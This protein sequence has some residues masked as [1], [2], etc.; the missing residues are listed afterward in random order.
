MVS[1]GEPAWAQSRR[2]FD[3][4]SEIRCG[5]PADEE[6]QIPFARVEIN[7]LRSDR[8]FS[9]FNSS[10]NLCIEQFDNSQITR[11]QKIQM[12]PGSDDEG[13]FRLARPLGRGLGEA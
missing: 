5:Q 12:H 10:L 8:C 11:D 4:T 1:V 6:Y 9:A 13:R 2:H 3:V 7:Y